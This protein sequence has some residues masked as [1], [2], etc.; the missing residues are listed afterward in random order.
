MVARE[1]IG[2]LVC[3]DSKRLR[4]AQSSPRY[5]GCPHFVDKVL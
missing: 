1:V 2:L 3:L 5:L 4:V